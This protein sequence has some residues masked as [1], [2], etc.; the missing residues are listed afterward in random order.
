MLPEHKTPVLSLHHDERTMRKATIS[1]VIIFSVTVIALFIF[2]QLP[3]LDI[4][5]SRTA[6]TI[7]PCLPDSAQ[8]VCGDFLLLS[9][10]MLNWL[11]EISLLLPNILGVGLF[12]FLVYQVFLNRNT[13]SREIEKLCLVIWTVLLSTVLLVNVVLKEYWGRPRPFR[14]D[15]LGGEH[16]FVL[17]GTI[18]NYCENNC[19]FVS[20]EASSAAWLFAFLVFIPNRWRLPSGIFFCGYLV[21]FSGLRIAFGRHFLSDVVMSALFTFCTMAF[22]NMLF[23]TPYFQ[24]L[25]EKIA[26]WSNQVAFDL[27]VR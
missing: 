5:I 10:G 12:A 26:L 21:F 27:K 24:R 1:F 22:L 3:G 9:N 4:Y 23:L 6:F 20:G 17:P 18:S 15:E 2:R 8:T 16:P 11:R 13:S 19:S 25:F 14:V 7:K